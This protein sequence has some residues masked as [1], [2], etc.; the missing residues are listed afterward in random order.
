MKIF[1]SVY[2]DPKQNHEDLV[3]ACFMDLL[4]AIR[5]AK[6]W[7]NEIWIV[8]VM[9]VVA[10]NTGVNPSFVYV[11]TGEADSPYVD[12][13]ECEVVGFEEKE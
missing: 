3:P 5:D 7:I 4:S 6:E 9:P 10:V 1:I 2:F 8:T 13:Y 11:G 12:I